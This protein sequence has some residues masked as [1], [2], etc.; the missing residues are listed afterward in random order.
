[1]T[2][3]KKIL[4]F[5]DWYEPGY[6]A[7]GPI[8]SCVNFVR[9]MQP[10]Y[11]IYVFTS[12]RDLGSSFPYPDVKT[13][14]WLAGKCMQ[15]RALKEARLVHRIGHFLFIQPPRTCHQDETPFRIAGVSLQPA[16]HEIAAGLGG[17]ACLRCNA[18][19]GA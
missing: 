5:A 10:D 8:R 6:K 14:K 3:R 13:D 15:A 7:G 19:A 17:F 18:T 11:R 9:Q 2:D 4:L 16:L 12:D 1:M